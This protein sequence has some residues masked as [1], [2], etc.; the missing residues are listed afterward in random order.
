M[1]SEVG[2]L[3]GRMGLNLTT[4]ASPLPLYLSHSLLGMANFLKWYSS[5]DFVKIEKKR[6]DLF[7]VFSRS[8]NGTGRPPVRTVTFSL[9]SFL[10]PAPAAATQSLQSGSAEEDVED[11]EDVGGEGEVMFKD[12]VPFLTPCMGMGWGKALGTHKIFA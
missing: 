6:R 11:V 9:F 1:E 2:T 4:G 8:A 7:K 3:G 12:C 5:I 10:R